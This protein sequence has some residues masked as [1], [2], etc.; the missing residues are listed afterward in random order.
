MQSPE[1]AAAARALEMLGGHVEDGEDTTEEELKETRVEFNQALDT[2]ASAPSS[3]EP[4][5]EADAQPEAEEEAFVLPDLDPKLPEDL[6]EELEM[7]DW[8]EAVE[9]AE[10]D[11]DEDDDEWDGEET[12]PRVQSLKA[13]LRK[14]EKRIAWE[15][16]KRAEVRREKW[17]SE[18]R[19]YFPLSDYALS[20]IRATSRRGFLREAKKAH[21]A[22]KPVAMQIAKQ[23]ADAHA[24]AKEKAIAEGKQA[25]AEA[26][27]K[28]TVSPGG[29][30]ATTAS[31]REKKIQEAKSLEERVK[32]RI[33][34]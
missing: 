13:Q 25:A 19:K 20:D 23:Y 8:D 26:W 32:A 11:D 21:E 29:R 22:I 3:D 34:G 9:D 4:A 17:E 28:P 18:A 16:E 12:D 33:F 2:M 15:Q 6:A 30:E 5:A 24:A 1:E 7:P 27:G 14:A 10:E 31:E